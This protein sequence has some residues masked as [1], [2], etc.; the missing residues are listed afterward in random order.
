[1]ESNSDMLSRV[2]MMADGNDTWDLSDNDTRALR[3]VL[4]ER[5][6][7]KQASELSDLRIREL[8]SELAVRDNSANEVLRILREATGKRDFHSEMEAAEWAAKMLAEAQT[9]EKIAQRLADLCAGR[10]LEAVQRAAELE[11]QLADARLDSARLLASLEWSKSYWP[12]LEETRHSAE[13]CCH[14]CDVNACIEEANAAIDA[15][16]KEA[17]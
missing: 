1:M 16:I 11:A 4:A 15:A 8:E 7:F 5:D 17:K 6:Q 13:C 2:C 3:H 10:E 9:Q 14:V 12:E